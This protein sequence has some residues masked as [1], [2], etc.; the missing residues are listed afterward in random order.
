ME[1]QTASETHSNKQILQ[2]QKQG[3]CVWARKAPDLRH[4]LCREVT[5]EMDQWINQV[6]KRSDGRWAASE[7]IVFG[8]IV[9]GN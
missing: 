6:V 7:V 9:E 2:I 8:D 5:F 4:K 3:G 1:S